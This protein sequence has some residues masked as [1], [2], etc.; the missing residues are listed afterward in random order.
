MLHYG[1]A[2][3]TTKQRR[4]EQR[5][6]SNH[7]TS[8]PY[9]QP[10]VLHFNGEQIRN[11]IVCNAANIPARI[12]SEMSAQVLYCYMSY[13]WQPHSCNNLFMKSKF[14]LLYSHSLGADGYFRLNTT[15]IE[16]WKWSL[17]TE[18]KRGTTFRS[19]ID[20]IFETL[21]WNNKTR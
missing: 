5:T 3:R 10:T 11:I 8:Q 16:I 13:C 20:E 9:T 15:S 19:S 4:S 21:T 18:E 1:T 17:G 6:P 2:H 7:V 14:N 12:A